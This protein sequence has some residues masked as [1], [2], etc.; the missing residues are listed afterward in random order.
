MLKQKI[1]IA[2]ACTFAVFP[3]YAQTPFI[4]GTDES[5]S[6]VGTAEKSEIALKAKITKDNGVVIVGYSTEINIGNSVYDYTKTDMLITKLNASGMVEWSHI[7]GKDNDL[8]DMFLSVDIDTAGNIYAVGTTERV[9]PTFDYNGT[10]SKAC[11]YKFSLNGNILWKKNVSIN[12][13]NNVPDRRGDIYLGVDVLS[14]GNII[15]VGEK[16]FSPA[17]SDGIA[18]LFSSDGAVLANKTFL[19]NANSSGF[20]HVIS[21]SSNNIYISATRQ[22][23]TFMDHQILKLDSD[24][25]IIWSKNADM[26]YSGSDCQALLDIGMT[27]NNLYL[28]NHN[29]SGYSYDN[30]VSMG[31]LKVDPATGN[32][33]SSGIIYHGNAVAAAQN[34]GNFFIVDDNNKYVISTPNVARADLYVPNYGFNNYI[35]DKSYISYNDTTVYI[36][37][38]GAQT[39]TTMD[40]VPGKT[41]FVGI[42]KNDPEQ[43]GQYDILVI[44][45]QG[46]LPS[47]INNSSHCNV[48][49]GIK[50]S[51]N[52]AQINNLDYDFD[53]IMDGQYTLIDIPLSDSNQLI[54][55]IVCKRNS[56]IDHNTIDGE[57]V[58]LYPN[59]AQDEA[60][61]SFYTAGGGAVSIDVVNTMGKTV[62]SRQ[63]KVHSGS[64]KVTLSTTDLMPGIYSVRISYNDQQD[65]LKL[66]K[67]K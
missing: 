59:P 50:G 58:L 3:V 56:S 42:G 55:E 26:S 39:I 4:S 62:C 27:G 35:A 30:P 32:I 18:T 37:L 24:L 48:Q 36:D 19:V 25:N 34:Q 57:K 41:V 14:N 51:D 29:G 11:I 7:I 43:I 52:F 47:G 9:P 6:Y 21:D 46:N 53:E 20:F 17:Y 44:M 67:T 61:V 5:F 40:K 12:N 38:A 16:D 28:L 22:G 66:A 23:L 63:L 54:Q 15:A 65:I 10:Y 1:L 31:L 64:V 13:F 45:T 49:P 60:I 33:I 8:E 2:I